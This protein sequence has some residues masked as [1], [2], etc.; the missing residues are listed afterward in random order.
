MTLT[1]TQPPDQDVRDLVSSG[2]L[3]RT[4]FVEAGAGTGKTTQLVNRIVNLVLHERV[5]LSEIAAITFTEAAAAELQTRIREQFERCTIDAAEATK[6]EIA[7]Q[8]LKDADL[9]A[10]STLHGFAARLLTEFSLAA[11]LPPQVGIVDEITSQLNNEERWARFVDRLHAD[12]ANEGL[13][14]RAHSVGIALEPA[15]AGHVTLKDLVR[16]MSQ[17]WDRL[18]SI[19]HATPPPLGPIDLTPFIESVDALRAIHETCADPSDKLFETITR[20]LVTLETVM[21][22][23]DA[24]RQLR[25]IHYLANAGRLKPGRG[26]RKAAWPDGAPAVKAVLQ[27]VQDGA[28]ATIGLAADELLSHFLVI[29]GQHV[30]TGAR[31]RQQAGQ[32]EFHDLLV[33]ARQMLRT[34]ELARRSLH[35]RYTHLLLDEFQDTDPIQ[36]ELA[37]LIAGHFD[38]GAVVG[39]WNDHEVVEGHLFF[40]GDPKQSIYRFRRADISLF[41]SARDSFGRGDRGVSLTT[42]F[43]T[44]E[45]IVSWINE[46]FGQLMSEEI[47]DRQPQYQPLTAHRLADSGADHRPVVL[48]GVHPNPK[49]KAAELRQA[50]AL[51]VANTIVDIAINPD[52]WLVQDRETREWRRPGLSDVTVLLPTRTALPYLR[53]ALRDADIPYRLAT[54]TLVYGT[55]EV[56]DALSTLRA[57]DDPTDELSLVAALRSPMFAC[58]DDDLASFRQSGGRW[59]LRSTAPTDLQADHPVVLALAYLRELWEE[60]WWISPSQLL[61]KILRDRRAVLLAFAERRPGDVWR[62]LRFLVDQARAFEEAGGSGLRAFADW[63]D[64]QGADGARVHEPLL[65]ETD[66]EAVQILTIHGSK[67]LEFPI[68]ILSGLTTQPN[69]RRNGINVAWPDAGLPEVRFKSDV[70]TLGHE[71]QANIE[72]EM[73]AYEKQRLLYVAATRARDHLV[74]SAHHSSASR[75]P[76]S[77]GGV[78][79]QFAISAE[80]EADEQED[81][82]GPKGS[83]ASN[84]RRLDLI[85]SKI[86]PASEGPGTLALPETRAERQSWIDRRTRVL[87]TASARRVWSA[88]AIAAAANEVHGD[89]DDFTDQEDDRVVPARRK[90]RAGSAIG[91][92]V[93]ATLQVL[94]LS[95]PPALDPIIAEQC[96]L[97]AIPEHLNVVAALVRSA[98][99][100]DAV[101]LAATHPHHKELFL[102]APVG[103]RVIEGYV[104]LLIEGP[105]GLIVVDYKTDSARSEAEIDAKLAAYEL[106]GASYAVALEAVTGMTV[107]ECRFVFCRASGA[108]ERTVSDL[109]AAMAQVRSVLASEP[110]PSANPQFDL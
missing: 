16:E 5:P 9:A 101:Q 74:V 49:V 41:L 15:Y 13:I 20:H 28:K 39:Q 27:G 14:V 95:S 43:R 34:N 99:G 3:R 10:I 55:Q 88:T 91:R 76:K 90:G 83:V 110:Q 62:R 29:V 56:Q 89:D 106:Q 12:E 35:E 107:A 4:L 42:N 58:S 47:T 71:A 93:H 70:R 57:I 81:A 2:G 21:S 73:D 48:G 96:D 97:E 67:G 44:V 82:A 75:G 100:S 79:G 86:P 59:D 40:V 84:V 66:E 64:L 19:E 54:G 108:I 45:P 6:R 25:E 1:P 109:P 98:L 52:E 85:N 102:S 72:E 69:A 50:E 8:A 24:D 31:E 51:D 60:R 38:E 18:E 7:E 46:L 11:G 92:A 103:D 30:L 65:P 36:I 80:P 23:D 87:A 53:D 63:A 61:H 26:G 78:I 37:T 104:D 32:L 105:S 17:N 77:L 22:I 68:T 94:D 33:L